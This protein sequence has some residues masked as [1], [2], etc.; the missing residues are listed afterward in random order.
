[1]SGPFRLNR[2]RKRV[3]ISVVVCTYNRCE[4]LKET[5]RALAGQVPPVGNQL[6]III[7]DN[8]STDATQAVVSQAENDS[9]YPICYFFEPKQGVS[10]A[11]N[12]GIRMA[13]GE[14]IAFID[15]DETP[16]PQWVKELHEALITYS[17]D[18]VGGPIHL[19]WYQAPP[20]WI[21]AH[22]LQPDLGF[23]DRGN[24][25]I[26][27]DKKADEAFL[28]GGNI[29]YRKSSLNQVGL[30]RS[31]LGVS[32]KR[33]MRGEDSDLVQ[34]FIQGGKKVLYT[35]KAIVYHRILPDKIKR[36]YFRR[37]KFR[38]FW[39]L[40]L[41]SASV[42][43]H[44]SN[45]VPGWLVRECFQN[46]FRAVSS[47]LRGM[48]EPGFRYELIFWAQLGQVVGGVDRICRRK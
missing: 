38:G 32:G 21:L 22:N 33:L 28:N 25:I 4:S 43:R 24:G 8:N 29:A 1:M 11:R 36:S 15:D 12:M 30:Y 2:G 9:P 26:V 48:R 10:H 16:D 14:Y 44:V 5:L 31:D 42:T 34:R 35:P 47:Y 17:A 46:G 19:K 39:S 7:I 3:L 23:I 37:I 41:M 13:G 27:A 20:S 6:E 45:G 40:S 18:C